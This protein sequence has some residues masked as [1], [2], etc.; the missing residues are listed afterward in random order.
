MQTATF[1][2]ART[3]AVDADIQAVLTECRVDGNIVYL[4]LRRLDR[5]LYTRV[6]KVL[7]ALGGKWN[8]KAGGHVFAADPRQALERAA[9]DGKYNNLKQDLQFFET[10][11]EIAARM[12]E[13]IHLVPD[14]KLLEPEAGRGRLILPLPVGLYRIFAVEIDP[15]NVDFLRQAVSARPD[16]YVMEGDF[17]GMIYDL[18]RIG[19]FDAVMMNSPFTRNQDIAHILAAWSLLRPGGRLAAICSEHPFFAQDAKSAEFRHWLNSV[20]A[21][22]DKLPANSF[23]ESGTGVATR[24]IVARKAD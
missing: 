23:A 14:D 16:I 2:A 19:L 13:A 8:R 4:P 12:A 17:L 1:P 21:N 5:P 15:N 18:G 9:G 7:S 10:P 3:K 11:P 6:D 24:L 20:D 22:C